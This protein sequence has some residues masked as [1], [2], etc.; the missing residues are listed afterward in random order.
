M[1]FSNFEYLIVLFLSGIVPLTLMTFHPFSPVKNKM[2]L[3]LLSTILASIPFII[4]DIYA[5][6][7]KHWSFNSDYILNF[8][9]VNLPIEEYLFFIIIPMNCIFIWTLFKKYNSIKELF[10]ELIKPFHLKNK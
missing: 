4:W 2:H 7:A 3:V 6:Y 5:T 8:Y 1:K 9:I 10:Q